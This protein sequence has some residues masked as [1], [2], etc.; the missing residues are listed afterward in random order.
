MSN[1]AL[2][3][4]PAVF[5]AIL[6]ILVFPLCS[7]GQRIRARE[8]QAQGSAGER[9]T[10]T[11]PKPTIR[12]RIIS[13]VERE[14][15]RHHIDPLL[16]WALLDQESQWDVRATSPK[17]ATGPMQLMP[18][19]ARRWGV[20]NP[21]DP[22]EAVRGG[23]EYLVYLIDRF[24]G[25]V[26]LGLAGYN[27]GEGSVDKYGKRIP[28]YR[29]TQEYVRRIA[30]RY[31]ALRRERDA[32]TGA[33]VAQ[34]LPVAAGV[35]PMGATTQNGRFNAPRD[36]NHDGVRIE[37]H[38][39]IDVAG[40]LN[41]DSVGAADRGT[42]IFAGRTKG[43]G[44]TVMIDHGQGVA[45]RYRHL[46]DGS[47]DGLKVGQQI[48]RGS[49][50]GRVG[51]TGE[52]SHGAHLHFETGLLTGMIAKGQ[53]QMSYLDPNSTPLRPINLTRGMVA[54][55]PRGSGVEQAAA[56]R[57]AGSEKSSEPTRR[58]VQPVVKIRLAQ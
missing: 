18:A 40:F 10:T 17:G 45:T 36:Y 6:T 43:G 57:Q 24:G 46:Q 15:A 38:V 8:A 13:A 49:F 25:N 29:E 4:T 28:P 47:I 14:A 20:K 44:N 33:V 2:I 55:R 1:K 5:A 41:G 48:S 34:V 11:N 37:G 31:D 7:Y 53:P 26:A 9:A 21:R 32:Q 22:D 52:Q 30:A 12:E 19:T 54:G 35:A 51:N 50:I 39:G 23:T 42:I 56:V 3:R 16:I 27:A 58:L